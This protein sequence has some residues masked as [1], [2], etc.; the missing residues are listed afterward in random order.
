M[1]HERWNRVK[2][3][4]SLALKRPTAERA[5]ALDADAACRDDPSLRRDVEDLLDCQ[6]EMSGSF[7]EAPLVGQAGEDP[8]TEGAEGHAALPSD[9]HAWTHYQIGEQLGRGG[10]AV[11]YKAWDPRLRRWVAI[12]LI[13]GRDDLTVKRFLREAEAQAGVEHDNVLKIFE[14]GVVG[15]HHYIAMQYVNG[16]T[17]LGVRGETTLD[18]KVELMLK[19]ADGL[20]AAH[21]HGLVHR[22]IKPTNILV[23]ESAEGFK[24]YLLDFGL[25]VE[26]GA[27]ALTKTGVVVG[28]PRYMAP[29]RIHGG[30]AVLDRRSDIYSLGA[31]FYEF[32]SGTAPF[33]GSSGLQVLV[34]VLESEF[35]PLRTLQP[36]LAPEI[37]AI[38]AKCLEKDPGQRYP[39][40]RA[41]AD[42]LRRYLDG[43]AVLARPTGR[44]GRLARRARTHPRLAVAFVAMA[45]SMLLLTSWSAYGYWRTAR[46]TEL[47]QRLGEE[48]RDVE[49]LFRAAEMSPLHA[50]EPQKRQVRELMSRLE[51][52]MGE[53]GSVAY[54][55]GHYAL[56]RSSLTLGENA[57][58]LQHLELAWRSGYRTPDTA[59][60]LGL[61]HGE[62]FRTEFDRAQRIDA[63]GARTARIRELEAAHRDPA[64]RFLE[65][66]R[67]SAIV[68]SQYLEALI[69]SLRGD[70]TRAIERADTAARETPWLFEARLL[71]GHLEFRDAVSL[72]LKGNVDEAGEKATRADRSYAE[73]ER[74]AASSIEAYLGRCAVAGLVLH[75][76]AHRLS[77][78]PAAANRQAEESCARA[79]AVEPESAEGYRLYAEAVQSW[80]MVN[81]QKM[82]DPGDSFERAARFA[83]RAMELSGG[84]LGDHLVLADIF[85]NR[86]WWESRTERDPRAAI[87][88]AVAAYT[89]ALAIDPRSFTACV[90]MGQAFVLSSRFEMAL[91]LDA[92]LAQDSAVSAFQRAL[93]LDPL[94][95]TGWVNLQRAALV[96]A[97]E[98][99][100]RGL[101][102]A[103]GLDQVLRF[104]KE[105]AGDRALPTRVDALS[106][107]RA[108]LAPAVPH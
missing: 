8:G 35:K 61:A 107:L 58:A 40:A 101:D 90:N 96:R 51:Q 73:A 81:G 34:D 23:E 41:L 62:I 86:A 54:G 84:E 78:D 100:R 105:L 16:P 9:L 59:A 88:Q 70:V 26:V 80:A 21:R 89:K 104:I 95:A 91:G 50:I 47:A 98:Q 64:L 71:P 82:T 44:L 63:E 102:P 52:I 27:P 77:T 10:M 5:A 94:L 36:A 22:D 79:L 33:A 83:R 11:V 66:G 3:V 19:I 2:G 57:K 4:L 106:K 12:K 37:D 103:P 1:R 108:R 99:A 14:T 74:V 29:E 20:H 15:H 60:A 38:I 72:Y 93:D 39:S 55:P 76:A 87:D 17:L 13:S 6:E 28:T 68:P 31:T 48:I 53:A 65:A 43:D 67:S 24:P 32:I 7:L 69:A 30:A 92:S 18:Q 46:Q 97:D 45:A 56:G 42:D 25:A 49:W 75:M 85:L